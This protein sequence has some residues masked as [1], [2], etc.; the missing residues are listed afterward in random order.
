MKQEADELVGFARDLQQDLLTS[1]SVAEDGALLHDTFTRQI[2]DLLTL[3]GEMDDG[4][5]CYHRAHGMEVSGY[6][7]DDEEEVLTLIRSVFTQSVPPESIPR[8]DLETAIRRLESFL[9]KCEKDYANELEP[10]S[11]VRDM[12]LRVAEAIRQKYRIRLMVFTDGVIGRGSMNLKPSDQRVNEYQ[13]WDLERLFR[14]VT[15][16]RGR[17]PIHIDLDELGGPIPCLVAEGGAAD[18]TA[19]LLILPGNVLNAIYARYGPRLLELNVRSFLQARGKVNQGIRET[20]LKE[21]GHFLAFNNGISATA[22]K[23]ELTSPKGGGRAIRRIHDFQIVNGGQT[24]AS[25]HNSVRKDK[26]DVSKIQVQAKLTVV[27]SDRLGEF[28]PLVSRYANSQNRVNEA[29]FAAND[30]YHVSLEKLSR[31]VWAP[32]VSGSPRQTKWFYERAR[33]QYQDAIA[34]EATPARQL[35]FKRTH[36]PAQKFTKTDLAKFVNSWGQ[37]PD[38][39]SRGSEKNFREFTMNL[40]KQG[41]SDVSEGYFHRLIAKA[42]MFR[43]TTQIVSSLGYPGY[44]ANVITY[45]I[46]YLSHATGQRVDLDAIWKAQALPETIEQ[47]IR[48]IAPVVYEEITN[49]P[50]GGN[51]TEW[52]K[53]PACWDRIRDRTIRLSNVSAIKPDGD[54]VLTEREEQAARDPKVTAMSVVPAEVWLQLSAWA[55]QTDNLAGYQRAL[56]FGVGRQMQRGKQIS[57]K[58]AVQMELILNEAQRLGFTHRELVAL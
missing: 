7:V 20:I 25:I 52:C 17:E 34:R 53:R 9:A 56:A 47:T 39:V 48:E 29:D 38:I 43:S 31:T 1:A 13:V 6:S 30:P 32:A 58:Q 54:K 37:M 46:A 16:G 24:T 42:I 33:G 57:P 8:T 10:A 40:A 41:Q 27:Q 35:E 55:K 45:S 11:P 28:V 18:Y 22:S 49:P 36:P 23:V 19:Y 51:V 3:A 12:A 26:A 44:R 21:P 14:C 50:R 2:I 15:S 5:A 4:D